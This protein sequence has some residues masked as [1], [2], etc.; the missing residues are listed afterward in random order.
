MLRTFMYPA[1]IASA[2]PISLSF[3]HAATDAGPPRRAV[4]LTAAGLPAATRA[5]RKLTAA[6]PRTR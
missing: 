2:S 3:G 6:R 5:D 4:I 1:A